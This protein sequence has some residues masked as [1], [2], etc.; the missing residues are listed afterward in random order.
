MPH[1]RLLT[2]LSPEQCL[3]RLTAAGDIATCILPSGG[4]LFGSKPVVG[5]A[6]TQAIRLSKRINY[7]NS[8]QTHVAASMRVTADGTAIEGVLGMHPSVHVFLGVWFGFVLLIGS[9][10]FFSSVSAVING[11]E[12]SRQDAWLGILIPP[13]LFGFGVVLLRVGQRLAR[14]EAR[15]LTEFLLRTLDA[16]EVEATP[17]APNTPRVRRGGWGDR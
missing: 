3:A 16:R 1:I 8:F 12:A 2:S 6:S 7:Q 5:R 14:D 9:L 17:S 11:V 4:T 13:L 15:F 10:V